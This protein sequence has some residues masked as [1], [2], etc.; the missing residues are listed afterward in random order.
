MP[1]KPPTPKSPLPTDRLPMSAAL[2]VIVAFRLSP[3][4]PPVA[5]LLSVRLMPPV[6]LLSLMTAPFWLVPTKPPTSWLLA[7]T[8]TDVLAESPI[9]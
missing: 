2:L 9:R 8:I 6:T 1:T 5:V 4:K 7:P 3:A